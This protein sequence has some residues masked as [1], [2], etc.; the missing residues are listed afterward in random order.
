ML[1]LILG[2]PI[3]VILAGTSAVVLI[4]GDIPGAVVHQNMFGGISIFS[5]L[6]SKGDLYMEF[7]PVLFLP[8]YPVP[9]GWP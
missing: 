8:I 6:M 4:F 3:F 1:L 5:L 7:L 9:H 2:V